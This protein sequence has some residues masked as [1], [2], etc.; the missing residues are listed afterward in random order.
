MAAATSDETTF[1]KS[2]DDPGAL[3]IIEQGVRGFAAGAYSWPFDYM[4]CMQW[5]VG[6]TGTYGSKFKKICDTHRAR[7]LWVLDKSLTVAYYLI[8][9]GILA[10]ILG[11]EKAREAIGSFISNLSGKQ[12]GDAFMNNLPQ[13]TYT[14][15]RIA[16]RM[17]TGMAFTA[18]MQSGGRLGKRGRGSKGRNMG[19]AGFNFLALLW[20][21]ALHV[22]AKSPS[23]ISLVSM[24]VSWITGDPNYKMTATQYRDLFRAVQNVRGAEVFTSD[25]DRA[26]YENFRDAMQTLLHFARKGGDL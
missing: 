26:D 9:R 13:I 3:E 10:K 7:I 12:A 19:I 6:A 24:F 1:L 15:S 17:A 20:G 8:F 4:L 14:T 2:A 21:S 5:I 25:A 11:N 16:G 22:S 18:W 23:N